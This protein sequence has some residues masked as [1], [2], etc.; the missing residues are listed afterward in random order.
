MI[1][2]IQIL[3]WHLW[4]LLERKVTKQIQF[5]QIIFLATFLTRIQLFLGK[6]LKTVN[7]LLFE[8]IWQKFGKISGRRTGMGDIDQSKDCRNC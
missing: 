8:K 4:K 6:K 5:K 2:S 7:F 3:Y 1:L